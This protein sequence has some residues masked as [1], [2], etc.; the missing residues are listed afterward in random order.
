MDARKLVQTYI[1]AWSARDAGAILASLTEDGTYEDPSTGGPLSG[2]ALRKHVGGLFAAFPDL[3]FELVSFGQTGE[4]AAAF[5]WIMRG[6]NS[7]S[8]MGL[9]PTGKSIALRGADF[10]TFR[11]G[12]IA[13]VT[14]YFDRGETPRQLGLDV[15]VQPKQIGPFKFGIST[16]VQT[17]K[18]QEP[19]AFSITFLEAHDDAAVQ[20]VREAS[21]ASLADMLKM[22]GFIGATTS[23]VGHRMVTISAWDSPEASRAVMR[24]GKHAEVMK[25]MFDGETADHGFTSVWTKHHVNPVIVR[26]PACGKTTRG[27]DAARMCSCGAKLPD[28]VPFW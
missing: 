22:D 1:D 18:T 27:P 24:Q 12:K 11:D 14:G 15:I 2:D 10:V 3:N 17:G 5:E 26:C 16:V 28:P 6:T 8:M 4:T 21:R 20:R 7:G 23:T 25:M 13:K 9:P 19:G